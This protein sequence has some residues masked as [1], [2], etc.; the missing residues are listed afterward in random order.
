MNM[1]NNM[2]TT[3]E[4]NDNLLK[5][6]KQLAVLKNRTFKDITESALRDYLKEH[7]KKASQR[8]RL[9]R[10]SYRGKGLQNGLEEG[11]WSAIR[12]RAYEGRG[13]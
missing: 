12:E 8:F 11:N 7:K 9:K 1:G 4:L 6:A 2:K 5:E 3:I 13:T 10:A